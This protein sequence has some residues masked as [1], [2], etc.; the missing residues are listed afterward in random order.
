MIDVT[1][2]FQAEVGKR[3]P[4]SHSRTLQR[5]HQVLW[6]KPLPSG[7]VFALEPVRVGS[8]LALRHESDLGS[9]VLSS[10]TLAN[11]NK[12]KRR[13]FYD[14]MGAAVNAAWHRNGGAIGGRIIFPRNRIDG[15]QTI[16]QRRGTHSQIRD[17]FDLTLEAI[18]R[19]YIGGMSPLSEVL[20]RYDNFFAL[21]EDF[22]GYVNFFLLEN[23]TEGDAVKF[24]LPFS[25]FEQS[26]LPATF[27][28]Y[29]QFRRAQLDFVTGRNARMVAELARAAPQ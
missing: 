1:F 12:N 18:R 28:E 5:Y 17:R 29:E 20:E 25:G 26:P 15:K 10:D 21:F 13:A 6:S 14:Q 3:D 27:A 2:D 16:N 7:R 9:F 4:D 19:H 8:A 11:S 23:L 24:Y 22:T